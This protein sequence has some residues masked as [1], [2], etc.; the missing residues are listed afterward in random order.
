MSDTEINA[1]LAVI[2]RKRKQL[3]AVFFTYL[4][5]IGLALK[6]STGNTVPALVAGCWVTAAAIAGARVSLS[7]C[8][9][10]GNLFHMQGVST[11]WGRRCRHCK[12]SL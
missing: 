1:A 12:L 3:W 10:C 8:P 11:S 2:R 9:A 6:F 5:A 4:P 7:R